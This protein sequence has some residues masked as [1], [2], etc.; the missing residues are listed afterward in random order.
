MKFRNR[1]IAIHGSIGI[2]MGLLLVVIS[3]T[4]ASIVFQEE[5]DRRFTFRYLW[6]SSYSR[7]L[8]ICWHYAHH[9]ISHGF[10]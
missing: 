4:G 2:L 1:L 10:D 6:R 3:L 9:I 8:C 5:S 7:S